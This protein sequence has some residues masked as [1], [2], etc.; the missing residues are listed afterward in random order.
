MITAAARLRNDIIQAL[1]RRLLRDG[2]TV[3]VSHRELSG[4]GWGVCVCAQGEVDARNEAWRASESALN[5]TSSK[6]RAANNKAHEERVAE[7]QA[8]IARLEKVGWA[9]TLLLGVGYHKTC[10]W[11][12]WCWCILHFDFLSVSVLAGA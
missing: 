3:F 4:V 8:T 1:R 9:V 12:L 7:L 10:L 11:M 6:E 2:T 5:D